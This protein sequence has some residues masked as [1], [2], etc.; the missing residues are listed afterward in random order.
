MSG[1]DS[2]H[3]GDCSQSA[4]APPIYDAVTVAGL[5]AAAWWVTSRAGDLV[6]ESTRA[7]S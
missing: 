7:R 1:N 2:K 3:C 5:L 6:V 4:A